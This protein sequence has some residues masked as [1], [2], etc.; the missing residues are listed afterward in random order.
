MGLFGMVDHRVQA[1]N[2]HIGFLQ[3]LLQVVY[4]LFNSAASLVV[5]FSMGA[6]VTAPF[7]NFFLYQLIQLVTI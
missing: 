4:L 6:K 3:S 1:I 2:Q 5:G 7:S